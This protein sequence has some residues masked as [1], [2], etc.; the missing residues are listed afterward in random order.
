MDNYIIKTS[1]NPYPDMTLA[2][3]SVNDNSI[4]PENIPD[5]IPVD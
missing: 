5:G 3:I 2:A 1:I 4:L